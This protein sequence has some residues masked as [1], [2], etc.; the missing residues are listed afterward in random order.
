MPYI[1]KHAII[2]YYP[3]KNLSGR[4]MIFGT[5]ITTKE[6]ESGYPEDKQQPSRKIPTST[7]F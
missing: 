2:D 7:S 6:S 5:T 1:K 4:K 3:A